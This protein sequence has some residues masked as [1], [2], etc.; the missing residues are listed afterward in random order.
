MQY[1]SK[2]VSW[3]KNKLLLRG[4]NTGYSIIPHDEFKNM[5]YVGYPDEETSLDFY[6]LDRAKEH[7]ASEA[8][9]QLKSTSSIE[10]N[11]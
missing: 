8:I 9:K 1:Y 5:F 3:K 11:A 4:Q 2:D 7:A 10:N 6:N